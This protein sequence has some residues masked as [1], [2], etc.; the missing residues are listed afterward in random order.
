MR[1]FRLMFILWSWFLVYNICTF[2]FGKNGIHTLNHHRAEIVRLSENIENLKNIQRELIYI[3]KDFLDNPNTRSVY[4]QRYGYSMPDKKIMSIVGY[5]IGNNVNRHSGEI[6]YAKEATQYFSDAIIKLIA[7][8][9]MLIVA[10]SLFIFDKFI[11]QNTPLR[12]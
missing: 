7:T 9:F 4:L 10:V 6:V 5:N 11:N 12:E 8:V 2:F 1:L 3:K